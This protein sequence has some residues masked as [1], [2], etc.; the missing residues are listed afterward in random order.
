MIQRNV[1]ENRWGTYHE[2]IREKEDTHLSAEPMSF[3]ANWLFR[4]AKQDPKFV[5]YGRTVLSR[6]EEK[7][8]HHDGHSAAPAPA[9]SEQSTFQHIMPGHTARYCMALA[10]L[11]RASGDEAARRK[12]ISGSDG[13]AW[14]TWQTV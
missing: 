2:D 3:T 12:A 8:V 1:V 7:L 11:Y 5:E 10:D 9:V 14:R 13:I 6:M 4:N